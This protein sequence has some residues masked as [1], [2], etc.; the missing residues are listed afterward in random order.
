MIG[1][2]CYKILHIVHHLSHHMKPPGRYYFKA[3]ERLI[4]K[5][6]KEKL[7]TLWD[8]HIVGDDMN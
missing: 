8:T 3:V 5:R 6:K 2:R 1:K 4:P 7:A